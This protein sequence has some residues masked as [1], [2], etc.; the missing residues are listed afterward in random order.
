MCE[1]RYSALKH[2]SFREYSVSNGELC[3]NDTQIAVERPFMTYGAMRL[4]FAYLQTQNFG[5]MKLK[6]VPR[7]IRKVMSFQ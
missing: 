3:N 6:Y 7:N 1:I 5:S 4:G 2:Q